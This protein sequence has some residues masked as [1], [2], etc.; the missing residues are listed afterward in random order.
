M[1]VT[2][3]IQPGQLAD[4]LKQ[5][6]AGNEVVFTQ[7]QKPV[8]KIIATTR[9]GNEETRWLE[10]KSLKGHKVLISDFTHAEIADEMFGQK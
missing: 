4:L 9:V 7:G 2:A 5:V 3:E 6:Q 1:T 8:A 10:V